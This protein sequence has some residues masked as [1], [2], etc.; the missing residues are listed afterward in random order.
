MHQSPK[1]IIFVAAA[2][3]VL[4]FCAL[5]LA[6][7]GYGGYP[8]PVEAVVEARGRTGPGLAFVSFNATSIDARAKRGTPFPPYLPFIIFSVAS[9][10][11]ERGFSAIGSKFLK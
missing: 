4:F 7:E 5:A 1:K 6:D 8:G 3:A 9:F 2:L 11:H 10:H